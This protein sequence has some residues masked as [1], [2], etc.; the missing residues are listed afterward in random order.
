MIV[1]KI[2]NTLN[3]KS[4]IGI[5]KHT[6]RRRYNH[7]DD[8]WN[9]PSVNVL[10]LRSVKKYGSDVFSVDII[11]HG[12]DYWDLCNL[13]KFYIKFYNTISPFGFNLREGGDARYSLLDSTKDKIRKLKIGVP[14]KGRNVRG[15]K[16]SLYHIEK[17]VS[18]K[19]QR[20]LSGDIVPW[21]KGKKIGPMSKESI[22]KS[23]L[24]HK[25]PVDQ[26]DLNHTLVS[27]FDGIVNVREAGFSP[28]MVSLCC[29]Y[30]DRYETHRGYIWKYATK[31]G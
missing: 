12:I 29:K 5:T 14:G 10:L 18:T 22:L 9:A 25:K 26:F 11:D 27:R 6:F 24:A 17:V 20:F 7:R 31:L 28:S 15:H 30:P 4:Y 19:K 8:W 1:Y 2:T 16:K 13:E 23:A 21:N 3:N